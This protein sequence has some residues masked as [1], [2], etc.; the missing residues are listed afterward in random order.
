MVNT[1]YR[2]RIPVWNIH[3]C[4][5]QFVEIVRPLHQLERYADQEKFLELLSSE[6]AGPK[7]DNERR[8]KTATADNN[9]EKIP[10]IGP[11]AAPTQSEETN[12]DIDHIDK[13]DQEKKVI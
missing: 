7:P 9:V 10:A 3:G 5:E 8:N 2:S 12:Q 4:F 11:K 1:I 13:G 6:S